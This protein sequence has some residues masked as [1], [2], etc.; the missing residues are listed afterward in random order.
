MNTSKGIRIISLE[1]L[2]F[3]KSKNI[4]VVNKNDL[5]WYSTPLKKWLEGIGCT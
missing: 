5:L 4:K 2:E 1:V 3:L